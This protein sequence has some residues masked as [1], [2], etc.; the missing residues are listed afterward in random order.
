MTLESNKALGGVGAIL[1]VVGFLGFFGT[2]YA[3]LLTL[4]GIILTLI[5]LKGFSDH[6]NEG[7]IFNN[8]LYGFISTIIGGVV[9]VAILVMT[10]LAAI[11]TLGIT[12][13]TEWATKIQQN[14]TDWNALWPWIEPIV[15]GAIAALVVLFVFLIISAVFFRRSLSTLSVK[16]GEKIFETAG[17]L[18]LIGAFLTIILVGFILIWIAWILIV[19]GFFSIKTPAAQ[20]PATLPQ[21]QPP[22]PA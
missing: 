3:A 1:V 7:G 6:Y 5:A 4:V 17:L 8:A 2:G 20:P 14:M 12:D 16:S 21:T 10:V 15:V 13:W 9:F 22:P 11:S 18:W 19:V